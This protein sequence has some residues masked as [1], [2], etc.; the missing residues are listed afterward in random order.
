MMYRK[1]N[2]VSEIHLK[3]YYFKKQ[4]FVVRLLICLIL[5]YFTEPHF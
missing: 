2:F 1:I 3:I 4:L 5:K